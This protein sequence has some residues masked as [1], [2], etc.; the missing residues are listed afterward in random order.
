MPT[1]KKAHDKD[2]YYHLA[3]DQGFRARSAFKLIQIDKRFDFLAKAKVCIDLC[4]APGGWCQVAAKA[5]KPGSIIIGVDLVPIRD[6]RNVKTIVADITTAEC[7]RMI[8]KELSGW[9]A[10]VVLCDGAPHIGQDYTKDAYVQNELVLAALKVATEHMEKGGTFVSKVYR[11]VDYN[12]LMWVFQHFFEDVQAIKPNSSR[13]QSS[14]IFIVGLKYTKPKKI[15]P[16]MLDP[17]HVFKEVADPGMQGVDVLH[18]KYDKLNQRKRVGYD[19]KLGITLR[20]V[21]TVSGFIESKDP[22]RMLTDINEMEFTPECQ[23]YFNHSTTTEEIKECFK[24]LRLLGKTDFR[25]LLKW[26]TKLREEE[27]GAVSEAGSLAGTSVKSKRDLV[28]NPLNDEE[29]MAEIEEIQARIAHDARKDKKKDRKDKAK[30]RLRQGVGVSNKSFGVEDDEEVF[31][32]GIFGDIHNIDPLMESELRKKWDQSERVARLGVE[33][34]QDEDGNA[35]PLDKKAMTIYAVDDLE[36]E[37]EG[38][39]LRYIKGRRER[40]SDLGKNREGTAEEFEDRTRSAKRARSSLTADGML[41][42]RNEEDLALMDSKR[43]RALRAGVRND[44]EA[45]AQ[46]LTEGTKAAPDAKRSKGKAKDDNRREDSSDSSSDSDSEEENR[47][48]DDDD[49][50]EDTEEEEE[51]EEDTE[52][53]EEDVEDEDDSDIDLDDEQG[54]EVDQIKRGKFVTSSATDKWFSHP[55][56]KE[57]VVHGKGEDEDSDSD[58]DSDLLAVGLPRSEKEKRKEQRR[59]DVERKSRKEERKLKKLTREGAGRDESDILGFEIARNTPS[60]AAVDSDESDL[61]DDEIA[62]RN[63]IKEGMGRVH[64]KGKGDKDGFD[65]VPRDEDPSPWALPARKDDR[66]YNS[67]DEHYDAHDRATTLALGTM[68]LRKSRQKAMVDASYN[69]FAWNDPN[70]LPSWFQDDEVRHNRPQVPIPNA[71]LQQVK[72]KFQHTGTKDIKKVAEARMR[73]RKRAANALKSA[74]KT[75]T[76]VAGNSELTESQKVRAISKAMKG[77]H[78]D[79]PSKVYVVARKTKAGSSATKTSANKGKMKFVDKRMKNDLRAQKRTEKKK[80]GKPNKKRR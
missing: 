48:D 40:A 22:V 6:I 37:L 66:D 72:D 29:I 18:K 62:H 21:S 17:N 24:D 2:K 25:K 3:K 70:D 28:K 74:K 65:I 63:K 34:H 31:S 50:E 49:E 46:L 15:D 23:K 9:G 36:G 53:E 54:M 42:A 57:T 32:A 71:L 27:R 41:D 8:N 20:S 69:R 5:M 61:D 80:A 56:F 79:K 11:S 4:A 45:Y 76:S 47:N 78:S 58:E 51:D 38:D 10:D 52:E 26:R 44:L 75:A 39:Y 19:E 60:G 30:E 64:V 12:A 7:R 16:K 1:H 59:K 33:A 55:V 73:K 67:G 14:E 35:I 68:M 13:A 43:S 77:T